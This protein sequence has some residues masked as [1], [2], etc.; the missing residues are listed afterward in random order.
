MTKKIFTLALV[1]FIMTAV[2]SKTQENT[3]AF[4]RL[5]VDDAVKYALENNVSVKKSQLALNLK[6]RAKNS[7]WNAISPT[8]NLSG[9]FK[10]DFEKELIQQGFPGQQK[11]HFHLRFFLLL[12]LLLL[13]MMRAS[14]LMKRQKER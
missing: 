6:K 9:T 5:T 13:H 14:F 8:L 11:F 12:N 10:D 4:L 3:D 1:F 7:S 2:F